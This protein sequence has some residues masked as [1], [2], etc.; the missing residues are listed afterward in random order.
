MFFFE[1]EKIDKVQM[2]PNRKYDVHKTFE[3]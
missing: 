1:Y 2:P 3:N